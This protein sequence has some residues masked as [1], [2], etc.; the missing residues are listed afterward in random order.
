MDLPAE[1]GGDNPLDT[2]NEL[3]AEAQMSLVRGMPRLA[4]LNAYTSV[5]SFA[6][7]VFSKMKIAL[8]VG[9]NVPP[10]MAEQLVEEERDRHKTEPHF[11]FHRG[12]KS[13]SGRSLRDEKKEQYDS[14]MQLHKM[15]HRVAHTGYKPTATE[16][17]DAHKTCCEAV[18]WFAEVSALGVKPLLPDPSNTYPGFSSRAKDAF[19]HNPMEIELV[20]HM[21]GAAKVRSQPEKTEQSPEAPRQPAAASDEIS[22]E[23][24]PDQAGA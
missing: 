22:E 12:I 21:L 11:L 10:D 8:L 16:A 19:D 17:R 4:V 23:L 9:K 5:E 15:R 1:F 24:P 7:V 3:L 6:N 13:A 20:K 2:T 14:L 18:R